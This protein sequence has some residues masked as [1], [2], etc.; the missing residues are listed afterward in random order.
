MGCGRAVGKGKKEKSRARLG[1]VR[2][3]PPLCVGTQDTA[4][5]AS[6]QTMPCSWRSG[7][8]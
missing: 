7:A 3:P 5:A 1:S 4:Q 8:R 2:T 6:C